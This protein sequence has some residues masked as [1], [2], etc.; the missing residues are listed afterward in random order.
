MGVNVIKGEVRI[1]LYVLKCLGWT[2]TEPPFIV[3]LFAAVFFGISRFGF[4]TTGD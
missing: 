2:G 4:F 3:F 1:A